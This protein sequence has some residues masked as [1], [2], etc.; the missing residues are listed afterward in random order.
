M[1]V[2]TGEVR[3]LTDAE[4]EQLRKIKGSKKLTQAALL[5]ATIMGGMRRLPRVHKSEE[6]VEPDNP[7]KREIT[8]RLGDPITNLD[9]C[10][11]AR[12]VLKRTKRAHKG[13]KQ[14]GR[15]DDARKLQITIDAILHALTTYHKRPRSG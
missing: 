9:E 11:I 3:E 15:V 13:A 2:D 6:P 12:A 4:R 8:W 14:A 10:A 1:N 7:T 5:Q